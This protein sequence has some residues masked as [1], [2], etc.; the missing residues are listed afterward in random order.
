MLP[1]LDFYGNLSFDF[2]NNK[3]D[4]LQY[5]VISELRTIEIPNDII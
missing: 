4:D 3:F 1:I 2:T 5:Y